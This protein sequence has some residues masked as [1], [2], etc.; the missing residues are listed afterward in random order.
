MEAS[1][2]IFLMFI[3]LLSIALGFELISKVP[4]Y[5]QVMKSAPVVQ[6]KPLDEVEKIQEKLKEVKQK[7]RPLTWRRFCSDSRRTKACRNWPRFPQ[8]C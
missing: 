1:T 8:H 5:P 4:L 2:L 3:L 6:K 7:L